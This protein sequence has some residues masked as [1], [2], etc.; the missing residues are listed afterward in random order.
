MRENLVAGAS[1][2]AVVVSLFSTVVSCSSQQ[3]VEKIKQAY[4]VCNAKVTALTQV[5][6]TRYVDIDNALAEISVLTFVPNGVPTMPVEI[7]KLRQIT[8][9]LNKVSGSVDRIWREAGPFMTGDRQTEFQALYDKKFKGAEQIA[10]NNNAGKID[11][12][13]NT[14]VLNDIN[15]FI[16]R[17][18]QLI[19]AE[20]SDIL[21]SS[22]CGLAPSA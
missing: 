6:Q 11:L 12:S 21:K 2:C 7:D 9:S 1:V 14:T 20:I 15:A 19:N 18:P 3:D 8:A 17:S 22:N 4:S 5:V 10:Q 16:A 13:F